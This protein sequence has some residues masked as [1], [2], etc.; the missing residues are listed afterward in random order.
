MKTGLPWLL[1]HPGSVF[2]VCSCTPVIKA[3]LT[4]VN[5]PLPGTP[6]GTRQVGQQAIIAISGDAGIPVMAR[7]HCAFS[8]GYSGY[9]HGSTPPC[10]PCGHTWQ[11]DWCVSVRKVWVVLIPLPWRGAR[12]AGWSLG[13]G[14]SSVPEGVREFPLPPR[15]ASPA[16]PP[17]EG[18][19]T[20]HPSG[21]GEF[22]AG[23]SPP[24]E[25]CP[26]GGVVVGV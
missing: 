5:L 11:P 13:E 15:Q 22:W 17:E 1:E 18:N 4:K 25:G 3:A 10:W 6:V 7:G 24:L 8:C 19:S 12:R 23:Y 26:K 14:Q 21:G 16:T 20:C 9:G 2:P